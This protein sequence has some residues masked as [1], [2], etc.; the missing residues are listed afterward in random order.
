MHKDDKSARPPSH[1]DPKDNPDERL[2]LELQRIAELDFECPE[3]RAYARQFPIAEWLSLEL[4]R[5]TDLA[6]VPGE[7]QG[8]FQAA[9]LDVVLDAWNND[10]FRE[11]VLR[12][13]STNAAQSRAVTALQ[14]AKRGL[15]ALDKHDREALWWPIS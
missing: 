12:L 11:A 2:K 5:L 8:H 1:V 4:P 6:R 10:D 9:V 7:R 3:Q 14:S 13:N 15:A